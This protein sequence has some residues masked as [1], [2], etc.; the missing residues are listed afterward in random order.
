M[1]KIYAPWRSDYITRNSEEKQ[2]T[3]TEKICIFC[4]HS[5]AQNDAKHFILARF[6]HTFVIMNL[7]PYNSGHLLVVPYAHKAQLS[8][9]ST[10]ESN[11]LM[12]VATHCEQILLETIKPNGL[13][14]GLNL[15]KAAG[16]GIPGHLHLHIV[17][18]WE[19]DTN[20][21]PI[22]AD[23]KPISFDLRKM[24]ELLACAFN[25]KD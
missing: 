9:L 14:I 12:A 5:S 7:Y 16:A 19:G 4:N 25:K 6:K 22:I 3:G 8:D 10:D 2:C 17:P 23:T 24:F 15:G 18:R 1:D 11:E 13:N 20:F 21:M